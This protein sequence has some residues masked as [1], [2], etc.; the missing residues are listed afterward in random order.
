MT[1][2]SCTVTAMSVALALAVSGVHAEDGVT[3]DDLDR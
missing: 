2:L 1:R 3:S